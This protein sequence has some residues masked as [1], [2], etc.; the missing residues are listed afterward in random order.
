VQY[1]HES[2]AARVAVPRVRRRVLLVDDNVDAADMTA[3]LL[4]LLGYDVLQIY[5]GRAALELVADFDPDFVLLDVDMPGLNGIEVAEGIRALAHRVAA[6]RIIAVTGHPQRDYEDA[7][8]K[9][10]F[11]GF[12]LKP[13]ALEQWR[14][15]LA[16]GFA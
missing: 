13:V 4:E 6:C 16:P 2:A 10:G 9:A 12:L 7:A 11:D 1:K 8:R 5:D 3:R 14:E 15:V